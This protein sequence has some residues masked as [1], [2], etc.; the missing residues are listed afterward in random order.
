MTF[1]PI[2]TAVSRL[3]RVAAVAMLVVSITKITSVT[4]IVIRC[5]IRYGYGA[6]LFVTT[7]STSID[8]TTLIEDAVC[9][10][11]LSGINYLIQIPDEIYN[12]P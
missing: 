8:G 6:V 5:S 1:H 11:G 12:A 10:Y 3:C 7:M 9:L 2:T 4:G